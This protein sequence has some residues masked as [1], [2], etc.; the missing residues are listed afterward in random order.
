MR[1]L[2]MRGFTMPRRSLTALAFTLFAVGVC[3]AVVACGGGGGADEG[4]LDTGRYD[5]SFDAHA[6]SS[7]DAFVDS[8]LDANTDTIDGASD[9]TIDAPCDGCTSTPP[10]PGFTTL[11][12]LSDP[13]LLLESTFTVDEN[14]DPLVAWEELSSTNAVVRFVRWD[15]VAGK[16]TT[17]MDVET[18]AYSEIGGD[19]RNL[20]IAYDASKK[21]IGL[22]YQVITGHLTGSHS[23]EI[24]YA[25]L[26]V[27]WPA[28]HLDTIETVVSAAGSLHAPSLAMANGQAVVAFVSEIII[29]TKTAAYVLKGTGLT[30]GA[31]QLVDT[32]AMIASEHQ[33]A[34]AIDA[35][36]NAAGAW[37]VA[38]STGA[39]QIVFC[40]AGG[41]PVKV[42]DATSTSAPGIA[43]AFDGSALRLVAFVARDPGPTL[44]LWLSRS[45]DGTTWST[46]AAPTA[47][48]AA[49]WWAHMGLAFDG[50]GATT[51]VSS[52]SAGSGTYG[53]PKVIT[54]SDGTTFTLSGP[55]PA[56]HDGK[57]RYV[58]AGFDGKKK[59]QAV[60]VDD[61]PATPAAKQGVVYW[62]AP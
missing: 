55:T 28:F 12:P 31:V 34:A 41:T 21:L 6:D 27:G 61:D 45:T 25:E 46:P 60:F 7:S 35:S 3:G 54:T 42:M 24:H 48:G 39:T 20:S 30:W 32:G 22:S 40:R 17:P 29:D 56:E 47:D 49:G 19:D 43:L 18:F 44:S 23:F 57:A 50:S 26:G 16:W 15:R 58:Q 37:I 4:P 53:T 14:G 62:R 36:G 5:A 38:D 11:A 10:P 33:A 59:L 52:T 2:L 9:A 1:Y 51:M 13:S 8:S